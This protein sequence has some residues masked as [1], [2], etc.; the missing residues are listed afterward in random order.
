[1]HKQVFKTV[2][3]AIVVWKVDLLDSGKSCMADFNKEAR[4][5][6]SEQWGLDMAQKHHQPASEAWPELL[7]DFIPL[8]QEVSKS[9]ETQSFHYRYANAGRLPKTY[10]VIVAPAGDEHVSVVYMNIT[11]SVRRQEDLEWF[12]A[13]ASHDLLS[14]LR[15]LG[16]ALSHFEKHCS[17]GDVVFPE[18]AEKWLGFLRQGIDRMDYVTEGFLS[19]VKTPDGDGASFHL[20]SALKAAAKCLACGNVCQHGNKGCPAVRASIATTAKLNCQGYIVKGNRDAIETVFR[21][22]I[23][24]ALK[25]QHPSRPLVLEVKASRTDIEGVILVSVEDNGMGGPPEYLEDIFKPSKRLHRFSE[26][27]GNG[28]GLATCRRILERHG[29]AVWM[30]S[31]GQSGS[32][33]YFNLMEAGPPDV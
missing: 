10:N 22:L 21:Q 8:L 7:G 3:I 15:E 26:I 19:Y 2:G 4:K 12:A 29:G 30:E 31:D 24:N 23:Q 9:G 18:K 25:Y 6:F 17:R 5:A 11:E 28:L 32:T 16:A 13:A 33:V 14:P 20:H 27:P 1:M